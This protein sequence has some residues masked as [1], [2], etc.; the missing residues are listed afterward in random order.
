MDV[1]A[2]VLADDLVTLGIRRIGLRR[3]IRGRKDDA[4]RRPDLAMGIDRAVPV[5]CREGVLAQHRRRLAETR[6]ARRVDGADVARNRAEAVAGRRIAQIAG[7][8]R[9]LAEARAARRVDPA[10][11]ARNRARSVAGQRIAQIAVHHVRYALTD[12]RLDRAEL[13]A[14]RTVRLGLEGTTVDRK[15]REHVEEAVDLI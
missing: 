3:K 15:L 5:T 1:L 8:R 12:I 11:V 4:G 10:D 7:H 2:R 6:A 13:H 14:P 9:R